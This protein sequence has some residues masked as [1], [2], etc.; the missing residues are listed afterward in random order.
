MFR[1]HIRDRSA[2]LLCG[3]EEDGMPDTTILAYMYSCC[4]RQHRTPRYFHH[5]N[6]IIN[7]DVDSTHLFLT[8]QNGQ[9]FLQLVDVNHFFLWPEIQQ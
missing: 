3:S 4:T 7:P 9:L 1:C 6:S 8:V 5:E 2:G